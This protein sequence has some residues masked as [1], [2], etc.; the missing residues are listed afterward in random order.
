M[1]P[2]SSLAIIKV[3]SKHAS[4]DQKAENC[5]MVLLR[6]TASPT[7]MSTPAC[8]VFLHH[9]RLY[10]RTLNLRSGHQPPGVHRLWPL[11]ADAQ[12]LPWP[13]VDQDPPPCLKEMRIS[14]SPLLTNPYA[15]RHSWATRP[16]STSPFISRT[17]FLREGVSEACGYST[18]RCSHSHSLHY[19]YS[20]S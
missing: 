17:G 15:S 10:E 9:G 7:Q 19:C 20:P 1:R 5:V 13:T 8:G 11:T 12:A 2:K 18:I 16:R 6:T 4:A 14:A 3:C